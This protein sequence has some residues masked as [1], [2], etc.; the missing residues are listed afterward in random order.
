MLVLRT[1]VYSLLIHTGKRGKKAR[2]EIRDIYMSSTINST[3]TTTAASAADL[4]DTT[5]AHQLE[6]DDESPTSRGGAIGLSS[7]SATDAGRSDGGSGAGGEEGEIVT[8]A[9]NSQAMTHN[10]TFWHFLTS[11]LGLMTLVSTSHIITFP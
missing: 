9:S 2:S 8:T 10:D 6:R 3:T 1:G 11:V 7:S 5:N 4:Q